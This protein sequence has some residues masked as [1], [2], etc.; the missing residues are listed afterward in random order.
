M[1]ALQIVV[2]YCAKPGKTHVIAGDPSG[3]EQ[4]DLLYRS[5]LLSNPDL[6]L[7]VLTTTETD[8]SGLSFVFERVN[9][10]VDFN[11]L[12]FERTRMQR[13]YLAQRRV[14]GPVAFLDSDILVCRDL[15]P[16]FR[17]DFDIGLT[18]RVDRE[19]PFNGGVILVNDRR[20]EAS[21]R[22]F[23]RLETTYREKQ[24]S[25]LEWYGDQYALTELVGI[26]PDLVPTTQVYESDDIRFRFFP[27]DLYNYTLPNRTRAMFRGPRDAFVMHFKGTSRRFMILYWMYWL[28]PQ[29]RSHMHRIGSLMLTAL[30]FAVT[31]RAYRH[32]VN[33]DER[34]FNLDS[35]DSR[36]WRERA[37]IAAQLIAQSG[38]G[39]REP[40]R[41]FDIGCGDC[42]L[43]T[44]LHES[45]LLVKYR[46]YDLL[47][48]STQVRPL[49][50]SVDEV[51][52]RA[53]IVV[54][55][56]VI[57]YLADPGAALKKMRR[58]A[59][60]LVISHSARDLRKMKV[61]SARRLSWQTYLS[62]S[63]FERIL[64]TSGY[65]VVARRITPD[66]KTCVWL[67]RVKDRQNGVLG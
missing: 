54:S 50:I 63:E 31:K 28:N 66:N 45:G 9:D 25:R 55:L 29:G 27:C 22:F 58:C 15:A 3:P 42:K 6:G 41:V 61:K 60:W 43:E 1:A 4:I 11:Q 46:G 56:G 12:M 13:N 48:Q 40:K 38:D 26:N 62:T 17:E 57:E 8:L 51:P 33:E 7:T 32:R 49:D 19:M 5:A 53:D 30:K 14:T 24:R 64:G 10:S 47:P 21:S 20:P 2:F 65:D 18:W 39:S 34:R 23:E 67:C 35:Q 44:T 16:L 59:P 37:E 52:E 36:S